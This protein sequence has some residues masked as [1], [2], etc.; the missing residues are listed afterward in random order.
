VNRRVGALRN[1]GPASAR[2][3]AAIGVRTEADLRRL[4]AVGAY[5]RVGFEE[6]GPA[7]LNLLWALHGALQ[8]VD[9]RS[10]SAAEKARLR[11]ELERGN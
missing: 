8:D 5:A 7:S 3:L 10:V 2:R 9:W 11:A 6:G 1:L 4:G